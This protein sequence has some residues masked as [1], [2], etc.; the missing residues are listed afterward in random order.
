MPKTDTSGNSDER[1]NDDRRALFKA[2]IALARTT[3][4]AWCAENG[5]TTGHLDKVL[6]GDRDSLPLLEKVDAFI[7]RYVPANAA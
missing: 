7:D 3:V 4:G 6:R 5:V 2:A 1:T